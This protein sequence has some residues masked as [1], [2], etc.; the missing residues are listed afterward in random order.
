MRIELERDGDHC[1]IC[2]H[3]GRR[4][5]VD[6]LPM[7]ARYIGLKLKVFASR[8]FGDPCHRCGSQHDRVLP[9]NCPGW[10]FAPF[11]L[12]CELR[13]AVYLID[14]VLQTSEKHVAKARGQIEDAGGDMEGLSDLDI[15]IMNVYVREWL[16][17]QAREVDDPFNAHERGPFAVKQ[18]IRLEAPYLPELFEGYTGEDSKQPVAF[19]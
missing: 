11:D 9:G 1:M 16:A 15:A 8:H 18:T 12:L 10:K 17:E 13:Q 14:Q 4:R 3:D 6:C 2:C 19:D 7:D 5:R